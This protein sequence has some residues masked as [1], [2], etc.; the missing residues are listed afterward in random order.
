MVSKT[1]KRPW[2][3]NR[4]F[5]PYKP[6]WPKIFFYINCTSGLLARASIFY[7]LEIAGCQYFFGLKTKIY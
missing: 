5:K 4:V 2:K 1:K 3:L 7:K 6:S